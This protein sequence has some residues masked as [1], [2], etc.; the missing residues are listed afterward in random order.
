MVWKSMSEKT[1][2]HKHEYKYGEGKHKLFPSKVPFNNK[3]F[4]MDRK[5]I[6]SET[7]EYK[8]SARSNFPWATTTKEKMVK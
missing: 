2:W 8:F 5:Y 3:I 4:K 7:S 6:L 1:R